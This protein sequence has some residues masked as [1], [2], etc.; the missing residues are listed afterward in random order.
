[1]NVIG[2]SGHIARTN[3]ARV[4]DPTGL[5]D[6]AQRSLDAWALW[7]LGDGAIP[8][9]VSR[10]DVLPDADRKRV[11]DLLHQY[12]R[13]DLTRAPDWRAWNLDRERARAALAEWERVPR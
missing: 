9:I 5:P 2:P 13:R 7:P 10:Y 8:D 1:L 12:T 3:L 6:D 4:I 11:F